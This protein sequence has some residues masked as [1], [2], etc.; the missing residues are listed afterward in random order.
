MHSSL[1]Y[2]F[3]YGYGRVE[4]EEENYAG[5]NTFV[6]RVVTVGLKY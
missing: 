6:Y 5:G 4:Y 2:C 3:R 1:V